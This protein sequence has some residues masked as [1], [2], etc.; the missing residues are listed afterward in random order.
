MVPYCGLNWDPESL[1]YVSGKNPAPDTFMQLRLD[2]MKRNALRFWP[3]L[4]ST[5]RYAP[6]AEAADKWRRVMALY[7]DV[8]GRMPLLE[9]MKSM[10]VRVL[11]FRENLRI[12]KEGAVMRQP[13]TNR[14][15]YPERVPRCAAKDNQPADPVSA[16]P[17]EAEG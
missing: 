15:T 3:A 10:A 6:N 16:N 8:F 2:S 17:T 9:R 13:P 7:D 14:I 5:L 11:A 1:E 12:K 4:S